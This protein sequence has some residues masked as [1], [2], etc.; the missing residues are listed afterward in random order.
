L[1]KVEDFERT[2]MNDRESKGEA[3]KSDEV[4]GK[5]QAK[6]MTKPVR[7]PRSR[8]QSNSYVNALGEEVDIASVSLDAEGVQLIVELKKN[9]RG[10]FLK[11]ID[12]KND[13]RKQRIILSLS[14]AWHLCEKLNLLIDEL[15]QLPP[16]NPDDLVTAQKNVKTLSG[17]PVAVPAYL[18]GRLKSESIIIEN[19][20]YYLDLKENS[21]GRF[22]YITLMTQRVRVQISL[23]ADGIVDLLNCIKHI[24]DDNCSKDEVEDNKSDLLSQLKSQA[25]RS[26]RKMYYFDVGANFGGLFCRVSEVTSNYRTAITIPESRWVQFQD[27][28]TEYID[29]AEKF[30]KDNG[31]LLT[32]GMKDIKLEAN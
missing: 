19:R 30:K 7:K 21:R 1:L 12:N 6:R 9:N 5:H 26:D 16:Y 24:I 4:K 10:K 31:V 22:L 20:R 29:T 14:C 11:L 2:E 27:I 23:K 3:V 13:S 28:M 8:Q 15:K 25:F 17:K 18:E 32:K